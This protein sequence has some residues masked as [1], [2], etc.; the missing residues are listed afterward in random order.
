MFKYIKLNVFANLRSI[1]SSVVLA[2]G[3][4]VFI[5]FLVLQKHLYSSN[6]LLQNKEYSWL[7][8]MPI[9]M[10]SAIYITIISLYIFNSRKS[11]D[12]LLIVKPITRKQMIIAKFITVWF[13]IIFQASIWFLISILGS[14]VDKDISAFDRFKYAFSIFY[15]SIV[16]L[17]IVSSI[18]IAVS[19]F[20]TTRSIL[21]VISVISFALPFYSFVSETLIRDNFKPANEFYTMDEKNKLKSIYMD[22]TE[23]DQHEK[24]VW[25]EYDAS[26]NRTLDFFDFFNQFNYAYSVFYV[27]N[28][29]DRNS[30]YEK[31]DT[32]VAL[33]KQTLQIGS[34][35]YSVLLKD[36]AD[37]VEIERATHL[38]EGL[39]NQE[40]KYIID[41][42]L[43]VFNSFDI[44]SQFA[45]VYHLIKSATLNTTV[46]AKVDE[47]FDETNLMTND[48]KQLLFARKANRAT[49]S[50]FE[51]LTEDRLKMSTVALG[52]IHSYLNSDIFNSIKL[53]SSDET[54]KIFKQ[55]KIINYYLVTFIWLSLALIIH[56]L[57]AWKYIKNTKFIPS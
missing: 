22:D 29:K 13:F 50:V 11:F 38:Q 7:F 43:S 51:D 45:V 5:L 57:A 19:Q 25:S 24:Q 42:K 20:L 44:Q 3:S 21:A 35:K 40:K 23:V 1:S 56:L 15:G 37:K 30:Y 33:G 32:Q 26:K 27:D 52:D 8:K 36:S 53:V 18:A 47:A 9:F 55:K 17:L 31:D 4:I 28:F 46:A 2:L 6:F 48:D 12:E 49:Y 34:K 10:G 39:I 14:F 41:N 54:I 16:V